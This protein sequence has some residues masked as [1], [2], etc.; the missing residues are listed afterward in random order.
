M[1]SKQDSITLKGKVSQEPRSATAPYNFVPLPKPALD[2]APPPSAMTYHADRLT[3][4]IDLHIS[5]LTPL[6]IRGTAT[7][8]LLQE[9]SKNL[10]GFY[11]PTGRPAIPGSSIRGMLRSLVEI[12]SASNFVGVSESRFTYRAV[13]EQAKSSLTA[14]YRKRLANV[15]SGLLVRVGG[16]LRILPSRSLLGSQY[17]RIRLDA[18]DNIVGNRHFVRCPVVFRPTEINARERQLNRA[19]MV[20][21]VSQL[22]G[23]DTP[24]G[25]ARGWLIV[26]GPMDK[27]RHAWIISDADDQAQP[28]DVSTDDE[29][30]YRDSWSDVL[31]EQHNDHGFLLLPQEGTRLPC[32]Y[33]YYTGADGQR[34]VAFGHTRWFRVPYKQS[35]LNTIPQNYSPNAASRWDIAQAIFGR[36]GQTDEAWSG[37]VFVEDALLL[38]DTNEVTLPADF[39]HVLSSPKPTTFQHYLEQ[40]ESTK[41]DT[42][43]HWDSHGAQVRGFKLYW[44][45]PGVAESWQATAEEKQHLSQ[46]QKIEPIRAGVTFQGRVRF[47]NLSRIELGAMLFVL[48]LPSECRHRLGM[49]KPLGLGSIA[50]ESELHVDDRR[51]RYRALFT[52][53]NGKRTWAEPELTGAP[54]TT[55]LRAAFAQWLLERTTTTPASSTATDPEA[56][57]SAA[58]DQPRLC[59]LRAILTWEGA[60][61]HEGT[62][63]MRL[64]PENEF[65]GRPVL[66]AAATVL[67]NWGS[68]PTVSEGA[69]TV[70][71]FAQEPPKSA[72]AQNPADTTPVSPTTTPYQGSQTESRPRGDQ[73]SDLQS[74]RDRFGEKTKILTRDQRGHRQT[75]QSKRAKQ[76]QERLNRELRGGATPTEGKSEPATS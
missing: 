25:W 24:P 50:I 10:S 71:S 63:Y 30:E 27:K 1:V 42:T 28:Q 34:R 49:G 46:L 62:R 17:W 73:T 23:A 74:L 35:L 13:A 75:K 52:L 20:T 32:F 54:S 9:E 18:V 68:S 76:A 19:P 37:R 64:E 58:W 36:V 56:V 7:E 41:P 55:A 29:R 69:P 70:T 4:H 65:K 11:A 21:E 51:A 8:K 12:V 45:R 22:D 53:V 33:A 47:E 44:H 61:R 60:P 43:Q 6:Y 48:D 57:S 72:A 40:P 39:T 66:S 67:K 3:G 14:L 38:G 16:R 2:A 15:S 5:T 31:R 26:S 59:A